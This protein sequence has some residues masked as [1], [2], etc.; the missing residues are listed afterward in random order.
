MTIL[1]RH[2]HGKIFLRYHTHYWLWKSVVVKLVGRIGSVGFPG[3]K[4]S[5]KMEK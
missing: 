4:T 1:V 2:R 5:I 3:L